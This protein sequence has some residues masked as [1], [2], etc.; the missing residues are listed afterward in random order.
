[1]T[2]LQWA[3][4]NYDFNEINGKPQPDLLMKDI[5]RLKG[6]AKREDKRKKKEFEENRW[7]TSWMGNTFN[8]LGTWYKWI[9]I[10]TII[11]AFIYDSLNNEGAV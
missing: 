5:N 7:N 11:I 4:Y 6:E 2:P 8:G 1:M 10:P 3:Q 9:F